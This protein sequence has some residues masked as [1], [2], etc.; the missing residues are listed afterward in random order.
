MGIAC[1]CTWG[2]KQCNAARGMRSP[3]CTARTWGTGQI[4]RAQSAPPPVGNTVSWRAWHLPSTH[5]MGARQKAGHTYTY[6]T[7][8]WV[9]SPA[10]GQSGVAERGT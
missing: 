4:T 9:G 10:V 7:H 3:V 1:A 5:C 2:G 8:G 6:T